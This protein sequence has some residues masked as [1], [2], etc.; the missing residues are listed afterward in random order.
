MNGGWVS[1]SHTSQGSGRKKAMEP[2]V[3]GHALSVTPTMSVLHP[4]QPNSLIGSPRYRSPS[5]HGFIEPG[6]TCSC[7]L[8]SRE[9]C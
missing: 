4:I 7:H 1:N 3:R 2:Q 5:P 9:I 6:P 8:S